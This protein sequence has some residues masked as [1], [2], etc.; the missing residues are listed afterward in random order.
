MHKLDYEVVP[1]ELEALIR[2]SRAICDAV[3]RYGRVWQT[4]SW[5]RST[6]HFRKACELVRGGRIGKV[7]H[8]EV[9]LPNG[10]PGKVR[11]TEPVPARA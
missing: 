11:P 5:Q 2:E 1:S 3:H 8:V 6:A 10:R 7:N 4:G 9:G